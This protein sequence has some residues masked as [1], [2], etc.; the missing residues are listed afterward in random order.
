MR[1]PTR[2]PV[3]VVLLVTAFLLVTAGC[4]QSDVS[5]LPKAQAPSSTPT[6][7]EPSVAIDG[8][9]AEDLDVSDMTG[10]APGVNLS[11]AS[12]IYTVTSSTELT[13]P[14]RVE[15]LLDNALPRSVPVFVVSRPE[16]G[17]PWAFQRGALMSDQRHVE[18][19]TTHLSDFAVVVMD[20]EG[21]LQSFRDDILARLDS[22][23]NRNVKKP[24]CEET[25][26][27]RKDGYSVVAT[28][29]RKTAY[30]CLG[31]D[32]D[33]R[34]LKVVNRRVVPIQ[35]AHADAPEVAPA[36]QPAKAWAPWAGSVADEATFLTPGKT[37][38]Y[39]VDLE[40]TQRALVT[41]TSDSTAQSLLALQATTAALA[42]RQN[43]FG[44]K[45]VKSVDIVARLV[46]RPSCAKAL[47]QGSD[48]LLAGCFSRQ[49][50][51]AIFGSTGLLLSQLT[52]A[53]V[54][55]AFL[56]QQFKAVALDAQKS[57]KQ[58]IL[59]RRAKPD[60]SK[61]VGMFTGEARSMVVNAEGLVFESVNNVDKKG[62]IT[63]VAD[64][65]YQ[66]SEPRVENGVARAQAVVTKV[67]IYDRKAFK[68]RIPRVGDT[69]VFRIEKGQVRSPFVKR[70]YCGNGAKKNACS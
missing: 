65:T 38:T 13:G 52:T 46:A 29:G 2:H 53:P 4:G 33:K 60:F 42:S 43:G 28:K 55:K 45:R 35:L 7:V 17:D 14:T 61:F 64:V 6:P 8:I 50:V 18:F 68:D 39:D 22:S 9:D 56:R 26:E 44:G 1:H 69:A 37:V 11:F 3:L 10:S 58:N 15:L 51:N 31:M 41:A 67:K 32:G 62:T 5:K 25:E 19:R 54:T 23:V 12:P 57:V 30:W 47:G 20:L 48:K 63:R 36:V 34:V 49:K 59:V 66:L 24:E 27:A 16:S 70:L 40:P 21:A